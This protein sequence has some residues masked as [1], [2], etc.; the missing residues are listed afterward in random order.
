[1]KR[2]LLLV[3]L[4]LAGCA[5][6][7][8]QQQSAELPVSQQ[9]PATDARAR[10]KVHYELGMLYFQ[11]GQ[12][13]IALDEARIAT[14]AEANYAPAYNLFG[15]VHMFLQENS[16]AQSNFERAVGLAPND[17]EINNNYGSF[18]CQTG[19][20]RQ[21][22]E[23][24]LAAVKN[25]LYETP[26]VPYT[27]AGRCALL[28]KDDKLAEENF[29]RAILVDGRNVLAMFELAD[30]YYR[31]GDYSEAKRYLGETQK[32]SEPSAATIWLALRIER[33]LGNREG[34]VDLASQLRRKFSGTPEHQAMLQGKYE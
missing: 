4:L 25:P 28:L 7:A 14:S 17:P 1:M 3:P 6:Q 29:R 15:L 20:E 34:E 23:R 2:A 30:I 10:A 16:L 24:F 8:I 26:T 12:M 21:G 18:L 31:R 32:R 11:G 5:Q 27:N 33:K 9:K 19:R 13:G 22:M